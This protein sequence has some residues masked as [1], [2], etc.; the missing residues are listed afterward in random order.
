MSIAV[1]PDVIEDGLVLCLDAADTN[2]YPR[3]GSVWYDLSGNGNN[4]TLTNGPTFSSNSRGSIVFDGSNDYV[5][6][7]HSSELAFSGDFTI[8]SV[9]LPTANTANCIIQKGSGNDF[10]Q[11]YW[12]LNDM[13]NTSRYFSLIMAYSNNGGRTEAKT[14]NIAVLN[15]YYHVVAKV[16]ANTQ[17]VYVNGALEATAGISTRLTGTSNL[18]VGWRV[19][20]FAA[21]NGHIP[22]VKIYNRSLS[23]DEILQNYNATKGR[24]GL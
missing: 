1:G 7:P 20:G 8:E 11:E 10:Y 22:Y 17:Y 21:T 2:S 18:R 4:G 13:R 16:S 3:T 6:I 12:L 14:G 5:S 24:F 19:D 15:N 23:A 9:I